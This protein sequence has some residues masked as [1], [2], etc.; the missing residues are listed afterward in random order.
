MT[1]SDMVMTL[2][3]I[4]VSAI[5]TGA[6]TVAVRMI[7][8]HGKRWFRGARKFARTGRWK[9]GPRGQWRRRKPVQVVQGEKQPRMTVAQVL[10][11]LAQLAGKNP[12]ANT[13]VRPYSPPVEDDG[14]DLKLRF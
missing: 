6:L 9:A 4:V 14:E 1:L 12:M 13:Q 10:T 3:R 2:L 7:W 8:R 5:I 11:A